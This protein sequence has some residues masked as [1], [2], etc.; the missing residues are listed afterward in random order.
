MVNVWRARM[1]RFYKL[2]WRDKDEGA[3]LSWAETKAMAN[4]IKSNILKRYKGNPK[5]YESPVKISEIDI[6]T[7]KTGLANWLA[8]HYH[9]EI[10]NSPKDKIIA[11]LHGRLYKDE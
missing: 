4:L 6:P 1:P 10:P 8:T 11:N 9:K 3:M 7:D 5:A 2:K